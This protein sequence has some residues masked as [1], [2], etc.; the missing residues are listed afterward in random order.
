[1]YGVEQLHCMRFRSGTRYRWIFKA[2][3]HACHRNSEGLCTHA[4][5]SKLMLRYKYMYLYVTDVFERVVRPIY[6]I[7]LIKCHSVTSHAFTQRI[8]LQALME[9]SRW[10]SLWGH[11]L[12]SNVEWQTYLCKTWKKNPKK[13]FG[14]SL[15]ILNIQVT[16]QWQNQVASRAIKFE[17]KDEFG[18]K[19]FE[20]VSDFSGGP[21]LIEIWPH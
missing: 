14:S 1:M 13:W 6:N 17:D 10:K 9:T 11:N 5:L 2:K 8:V 20:D 12:R 4:A 3:V 18:S 19:K 16:C 21:G 15:Y 7:A